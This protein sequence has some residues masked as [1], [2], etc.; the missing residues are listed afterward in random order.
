[1]VNQSV[2]NR[3]L[4]SEVNELT[5]TVLFVTMAIQ[6]GAEKFQL[7]GFELAISDKCKIFLVKMI[8][9]YYHANKTHFHNKGFA[10]GLVLRV[11]VFGTR[12]WTINSGV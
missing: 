5:V 12:K 10:L 6:E 3:G 8:F 1:M 4:N 9:F 2:L 7:M 11:R